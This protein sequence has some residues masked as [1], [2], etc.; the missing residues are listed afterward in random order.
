MRLGCNLCSCKPFQVRSAGSSAKQVFK[1]RRMKNKLERL[2]ITRFCQKQRHKS[3][4][5]AN[6][7]LGLFMEIA[8]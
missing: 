3:F 7:R 2:C 5:A 6:I 8:V 1:S 4:T